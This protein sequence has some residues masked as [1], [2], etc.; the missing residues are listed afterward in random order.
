MRTTTLD[1][2]RIVLMHVS[3]PPETIGRRG[4]IR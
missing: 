3:A 1:Y 4:I 2:D